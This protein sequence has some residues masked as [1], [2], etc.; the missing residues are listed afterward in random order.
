MEKVFRVVMSCFIERKDI[1][2]IRKKKTM[3]KK[4]LL[5]IK[6]CTQKAL[7]FTIKIQ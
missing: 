1:N 6:S 3:N 4:N 5:V 7:N 2:F